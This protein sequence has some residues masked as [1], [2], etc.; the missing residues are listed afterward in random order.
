MLNL[1]QRITFP[2]AKLPVSKDTPGP[3][4]W[5]VGPYPT[6]VMVV[7]EAPGE[8]EERLKVPFVGESGKLLDEM[9]VKVGLARGD[10]YITNAVK[11]RPVSP[12]G[13]TKTPSPTLIKK[14]APLLWDEINQVRPEI[15]FLTGGPATRAVYPATLPISKARGVVK[16]HTLGF[17]TLSTFHPAYI[18]RDVERK[19]I[20]ESDFALLAKLVRGE[21]IEFRSKVHKVCAT[22]ESVQNLVEYCI[23]QA[24]EVALDIETTGLDW[25]ND[26]LL[27]ICVSPAPE[28][29]YVVPLMGQ[30]CS[31]IWG[32]EDKEKV[33][34]LLRQL[35]RSAT[36]KIFHNGSFDTK[37]LEHRGFKVEN[38]KYDTLIEH[39]LL[40]EQLPHDLDFICNY[41]LQEPGHK[42]EFHSYLK[43][44]TDTFDVVPE[45][46]LW[47][48]AA[49]D[50]D[51][52]HRAHALFITRL[53]EENPGVIGFYQTGLMPLAHALKN[54]ELRG[55]YV[56]Q[57]WLQREKAQYTSDANLVLGEIHT[58]VGD[59]NLD[60]PKQ[61]S[62]LFYQRRGH[63]VQRYTKSGAPSTDKDTLKILAKVDPLASKL[64][65]YRKN[66]HAIEFF[67][68]IL[69]HTDPASFVHANYN[70]T[71]A[72][73][74]RISSSN[75]NMQ[76]GED[77]PRIQGIFTALPESVRGVRYVFGKA[78]Y[79]QIELLVLAGL[80]GDDTMLHQ[81][82]QRTD[83]HKL[84][85]STI[86]GV[87]PE[88]IT[89][90]VRSV[91][92]SIVS[93]G[94]IYG[95]S[96]KALAADFGIQES[97]AIEIIHLYAKM[98]PK[99]WEWCANQK[100]LALQQGYVESPLGFRRHFEVEGD[101]SWGQRGRIERQA[102][103]SPVQGSAAC[104][105][106]SAHVRLE[107]AYGRGESPNIICATLH[108]A[109]YFYMPENSWEEQVYY[110]REMMERPI[111]W[112]GDQ[113]PHVKF[114]VGTRWGDSSLYDED[115]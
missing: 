16:Q 11:K 114:A 23:T 20:M 55:I 35:L 5:G 46:V 21:D 39:H 64:L 90:D 25:I 71:G 94:I 14:W 28:E 27:C 100:R 77:N 88:E 38:W 99:C 110:I 45:R 66:S 37:F 57:E 69:E 111:P 49:N 6:K 30:H 33:Y 58:E 109:L 74:Y 18:L 113:I 26:K 40:S 102:V 103:N 17:K 84:I 107:Q 36:P 63:P 97:E 15:I 98:Y 42:E 85:A 70:I 4:V 32:A 34:M 91:I 96:A 89:K 52:T 78:D 41:E 44:K 61:L 47:K 106:N 56:D 9:L 7:G 19:P 76:N 87:P 8:T 60:S 93:F 10:I 80:A 13:E 83:L 48:Y 86:L 50:G 101:L 112:L 115:K 54:L 92:K 81:Y 108:D 53:Q 43:K 31:E 67:D 51:Y 73:T 104:I 2:D 12:T 68:S 22:V 24:E 29:A 95:R 3:P 75:P 72:A 65:V 59:V 1:H 82:S 79:S 105:T 62:D